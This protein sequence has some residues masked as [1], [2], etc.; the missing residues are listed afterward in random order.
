MLL[1]GYR[2]QGYAQPEIAQAVQQLLIPNQRCRLPDLIDHLMHHLDLPN[3]GIVPTLLHLLWHDQ[4]RTNMN[5]L[6]CMAAVPNRAAQVW[7]P[8][9][10]SQ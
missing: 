3:H 6:L 8:V 9:E 5:T 1:F 4:L 10:N 7:L 2:P